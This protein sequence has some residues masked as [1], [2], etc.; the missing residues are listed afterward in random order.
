MQTLVFRVI[1][2]MHTYKK[3]DD[4]WQVLIGTTVSQ[5]LTL[6]LD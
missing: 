3:T 5:Q 6:F 4:L 2:Y 1:I